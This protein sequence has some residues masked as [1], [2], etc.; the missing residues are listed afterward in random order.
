MI[1]YVENRIAELNGL[2]DDLQHDMKAAVKDKRVYDE[3][4]LM[5]EYRIAEGKLEVLNEVLHAQK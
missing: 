1:Q 3:V 2:L 5:V 4:S